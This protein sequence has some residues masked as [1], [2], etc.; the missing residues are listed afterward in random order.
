MNFIEL[1]KHISNVFDYDIDSKIEYALNLLNNLNTSRVGILNKEII[2]QHI[3]PLCHFYHIA[4]VTYEEKAPQKDALENVFG[5]FRYMDDINLIYYI[6]G[7]GKKINF[8]LGIEVC[9]YNEN[10]N[11]K[12][13][14]FGKNFLEPTIQGNFRGC[15]LKNVEYE[16]KDKLLQEISNSKYFGMLE[17]V[18]SLDNDKE[19]F[20]GTDRLID[21][22]QGVSFGVLIIA[23][24]YSEQDTIRLVDSIYKAY[25]ELSILSNYSVQKN[26]SASIG[27]GSNKVF[28][29]N[30]QRYYNSQKTITTGH[31]YIENKNHDKRE[32]KSSQLSCSISK[33]LTNSKTD[34]NSENDNNTENSKHSY[35]TSDRTSEQK[36]TQHND[37]EGITLNKSISETIQSGTQHMNTDNKSKSDTYSCSVT[38]NKNQEDNNNLNINLSKLE[39]LTV[40]RKKASDWIKYIDDVLLPRIDQGNG[41]GIFQVCTFLFSSQEVTLKRLANNMISL[42]SG[43]KNNKA[44]LYYTK[45]NNRIDNEERIIHTF[46]KL[47]IPCHIK[48]NISLEAHALTS[49]SII[50]NLFYRGSWMSS[51][52]LGILAGL[53]QRDVIGLTLREEV[54]FGLNVS[55]ISENKII[56][57][58]LVQGGVIKE[59]IDVCL[60]RK[61]LDKHMFVAGVT[62]SGKTTTCLHLIQESNLPILVI[63]PVKTEYRSLYGQKNL[64]N[65]IYFTPG[66]QDL[67]P[68]FLNPFELLPNESISS[69]ADMIKATFEASF[70]MEAAIPQILETSVYY[71]YEMKGWDIG[72]T[73]W[74]NKNNN[75]IDGPFSDGQQAFPTLSDFKVAV[76]FVVEQQGFDDRLRDEYLGSINARIESLL[77]GAK[78]QMLNVS[79]SIDFI[80]LIHR[81]VVIELEEI[82]NGAEKSMIMGF[83][84]TN[85]LQAI[86]IAKKENP[87]FQHITLI[88]EAHRLLSKFMP[89]DSLAKKQGVEVFADMLAEVRKYGESLIIVDQIPDKMTPEVLKNTSTKIIH[90]IFAQDDKEAIGNTMCLKDEQK[91]YLSNL[92]EGRAIVLSN[93]WDKAVQVQIINSIN[94]NIPLATEEII[95]RTNINY[96]MEDKVAKRCIYHNDN[97]IPNFDIINFLRFKQRNYSW[98]ILLKDI[99]AKKQLENDVE[100]PKKIA[101]GIK[102]A[103]KLFHTNIKDYLLIEM[104]LSSIYYDIDEEINEKYND[105]L[106]NFIDKICESKY[107][108]EYKNLIIQFL[109]NLYN[110]I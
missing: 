74:N 83:I 20:Q 23:K 72:T 91:S 101:K 43:P 26:Q 82:K 4:E 62:G 76:K 6:K 95:H 60:D 63:E 98:L 50:D 37:N 54:D 32:D 66:K 70:E 109:N 71:A 75:D 10:E 106:F 24:P 104:P 79:R 31:N 19:T 87:N 64:Q 22:M 80:D 100:I 14:D 108:D 11:I 8:Y 38:R 28:S 34:E 97:I 39:Q 110:N 40:Q 46:Q 13:K 93:G 49:R 73:T 55:K 107:T 1:N 67:A 51:E 102:T 53:P 18:P 96:Y 59:K 9:K 90:K 58:K 99:L 41:K 48:N 45:L 68:F 12:P 105:I 35:G 5:A 15:K 86:K 2:N 42:Y 85:I 21:V 16:E 7:D 81:K 57:G 3:K 69:R 92:Q 36:S 61:H 88:E 89:G 56:L 77:V 78:G 30:K 94:N 29:S 84:L 65:I 103:K 47:Q 33:S 52:E 25:D 27:R 44:P 17:G